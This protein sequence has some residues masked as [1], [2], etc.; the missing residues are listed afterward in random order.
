LERLSAAFKAGVD[1]GEF[2]GAVV[3][4][5]RNRGDFED[6]FRTPIELSGMATVADRYPPQKGD[7]LDPPQ[8]CPPRP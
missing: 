1:K 8:Q 2:P 6:Q 4:I 5:A 3:L 7:L